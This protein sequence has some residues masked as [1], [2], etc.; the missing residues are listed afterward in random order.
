MEKIKVLV[1]DDSSIMRKL[2]AKIVSDDPKLEVV[3]TAMNGLFA[4][5]KIKKFSPD[6]VLLDLEMPGM[7]GLDFLKMRKEL[8]IDTPVIV[9]SSLGKNQP[10]LV[11]KTIEMGAS[12]FVIKPSGSISMDIENLAEEIRSKIHFY[13]KKN[14]LSPKQK[15][16]IEQEELKHAQ[17]LLNEANENKVHIEDNIVTTKATLEEKLKSINE[18]KLIAIGISTGGPNALR[19]IL[20]DF[21]ISFPVPIIIVQHMP[22][23]FTKEFAKGLDDICQL[24]V[25]EA[26]DNEEIE[27]GKIYIA[28]GDS[29]VGVSFNGRKMQI[30][31]DSSP[32]INGHKPSVGFLFNSI[33]DNIAKN[34][35]SVIM[36]GMGRDG[37]NEITELSKKG[38]ITI[39]QSGN[40]CVV[41]GMPKVAIENGGI[42]EVIPL[43]KITDRIIE[44]VNTKNA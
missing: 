13:H 12:D 24:N 19:N 16:I 44:I 15:E 20:P 30:N 41:F 31:L 32:P 40:T 3:D 2:I 18:I 39:A 29:H 4:L 11:F 34:C 6:I 27:D 1:V 9:I 8:V 21:P 33:K 43:D 42:D 28:P 25:V 38:A 37:A 17:S 23:G 10:E 14:V 5:K 26:K 35:I 36:T 22:P 7:N